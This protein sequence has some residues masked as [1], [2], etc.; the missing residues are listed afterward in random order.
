MKTFS[1]LVFLVFLSQISGKAQEPNASASG[2]RARAEGDAKRELAEAVKREDWETVKHAADELAKL[3]K[4]RK[5][6]TE[7]KKLDF[8]SSLKKSGFSLSKSPDEEKKGATFSFTD[9]RQVG[10]NASFNAEFYLR[11]QKPIPFQGSFSPTLTW[12]DAPGVSVQGK[13][14]SGSSDSVTTDAWRFRL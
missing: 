8:I 9:N 10:T 3:N 11:W 12:F 4:D 2:F 5:H 7:P 1:I 6:A 13:L 14:T